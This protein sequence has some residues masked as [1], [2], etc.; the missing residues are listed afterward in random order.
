[1]PLMPAA[2]T[3]KDVFIGKCALL[4]A[5]YTAWVAIVSRG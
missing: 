3:T 4:A 2:E 1:M 5:H